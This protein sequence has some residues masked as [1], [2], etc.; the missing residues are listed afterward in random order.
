M[1]TVWMIW[2]VLEV[3]RMGCWIALALVLLAAMIVILKKLI[4]DWS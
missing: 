1:E 2:A 3:I 4:E